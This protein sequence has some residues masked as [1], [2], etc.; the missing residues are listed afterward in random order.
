MSVFKDQGEE[1]LRYLES[2]YIT[3]QQ[4]NFIAKFVKAALA[5]E[6]D[7]QKAKEAV[8]TNKPVAIKKAAPKKKK[9]IDD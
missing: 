8:V 3:P 9:V 1:A 5:Q 6:A 7:G 4:K 2:N